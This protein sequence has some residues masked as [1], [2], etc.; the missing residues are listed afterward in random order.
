MS[1]LKA[2]DTSLEFWQEVI[3]DLTSICISRDLESLAPALDSSL[4]SDDIY[5]EPRS[6]HSSEFSE[7]SSEKKSNVWTAEEDKT[8]I[9]QAVSNNFKWEEVAKS[10]PNTSPR[11]VEQ[12]WNTLNEGKQKIDWTNEQDRLIYKLYQT[13]GGQWKKI[14]NFFPGI[15]SSAIK[16]RFYGS[17]KRK[18]T[19]SPRSGD[20]K[21]S[22]GK[23]EI[24][25][26]PLSE[27]SDAEK[28]NQ[29]QKLYEKLFEIQNNIDSAKTQI[30]EL[31][32]K[33]KKPGDVESPK[34]RVSK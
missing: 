27:L 8:L 1:W 7:K 11:S 21:T 34:F 20:E 31:A 29:I 18:M 12:R 25:T 14:S 23:F 32:S 5:P 30:I 24:D 19:G 9:D 4:K 2:I 3:P 26:R 15:S 17:I 28:R 16:N 22:D 33:N 10:F 13:H 6:I